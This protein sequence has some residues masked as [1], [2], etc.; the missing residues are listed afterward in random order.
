MQCSYWPHSTLPDWCHFGSKQFK[1][2]IC[3][4]IFHC[5]S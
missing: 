1:T 4:L 3:A 2:I 5:T